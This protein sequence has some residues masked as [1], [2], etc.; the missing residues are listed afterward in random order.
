MPLLLLRNQERHGVEWMLDHWKQWQLILPLLDN[1]DDDKRMIHVDYRQERQILDEL[2]QCVQR[3]P[4]SDYVALPRP[5]SELSCDNVLV[6]ERLEGRYSGGG[7][8]GDSRE[9]GNGINTTKSLRTLL[10]AVEE[11]LSKAL[12]GNWGKALEFLEKEQQYQAQQHQP[13]SSLLLSKMV[14]PEKRV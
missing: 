7:G 2:Y 13:Q 11:G 10:H 12:D 14:L 4:Y 5:V 9:D 6:V 8:A 3:S 1:N